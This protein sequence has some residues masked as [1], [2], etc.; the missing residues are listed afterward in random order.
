MPDLSLEDVVVDH[1][2]IE[3]LRNEAILGVLA[4]LTS[5]DLHEAAV[6]ILLRIELLLV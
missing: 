5:N 1:L 2:G 4:D 6:L 3:Y